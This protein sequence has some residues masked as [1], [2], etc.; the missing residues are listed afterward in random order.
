MIILTNHPPTIKYLIMDTARTYG[1]I[2]LIVLTNLGL[3]RYLTFYT[4]TI[5]DVF[6]FTVYA[7]YMFTKFMTQVYVSIRS[8]LRT[9][10]TAGGI[11]VA[12]LI[13]YAMLNVG[14]M[15]SIITLTP[16]LISALYLKRKWK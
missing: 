12:Q 16:I 3:L 11:I 2:M 13:A 5:I 8:N 9:I 4:V 15:I 10:L 1:K 14:V 6:L 7:T